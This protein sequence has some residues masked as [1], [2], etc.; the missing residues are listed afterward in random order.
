[1]RGRARQGRGRI[2][3]SGPFSLVEKWLKHQL[4]IAYTILVRNANANQ[5]E[6]R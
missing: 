3:R 5:G 2:E 6:M 4:Q 1:M